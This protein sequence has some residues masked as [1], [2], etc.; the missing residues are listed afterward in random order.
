MARAVAIALV[1]SVIVAVPVVVW[2]GGLSRAFTG[3]SLSTAAFRA[4]G[5][6]ILFVALCQVYLGGTRGLKIMHY[7]LSIYWAGQPSR[8]SRC[9]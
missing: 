7:T 8:G 1:A 4:A 5:L 9:C 3:D 2:A 6:A